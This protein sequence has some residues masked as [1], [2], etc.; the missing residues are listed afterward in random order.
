MWTQPAFLVSP[1]MHAPW[2]P[3][4]DRDDLL[5]QYPPQATKNGT[6]TFF[7]VGNRAAASSFGIEGAP[8]GL[9]ML[10]VP[11]DRYSPANVRR[12]PSDVRQPNNRQAYSQARARAAPVG[13]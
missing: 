9:R 5:R 2:N 6:P 11:P 12:K 3:P 8:Q 13:A 1:P 10:L 4:S 7:P